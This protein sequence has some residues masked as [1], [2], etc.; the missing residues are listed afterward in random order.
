VG[1]AKTGRK[2]DSHYHFNVEKVAP[3]WQFTRRP[4]GFL[5]I[6]PMTGDG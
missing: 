1:A 4:F 3:S 6:L 2:A 5:K